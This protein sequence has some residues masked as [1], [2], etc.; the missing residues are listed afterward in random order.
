MGDFWVIW[1]S[2]KMTVERQE[3]VVIDPVYLSQEGG[4][5]PRL[6]RVQIF[7]PDIQI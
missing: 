7:D 5:R 6:Q 3:L 4:N 1:G 2:S